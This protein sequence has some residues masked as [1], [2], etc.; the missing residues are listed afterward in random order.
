[1]NFIQEDLLS[2]YE[3]AEKLAAIEKKWQLAEIEQRQKRE[4]PFLKKSANFRQLL[5]KIRTVR[6]RVSFEVAN[7]CPDTS[8]C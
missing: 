8:P 6:V 7:P 1:M 3:R 4:R 2:Q 5:N